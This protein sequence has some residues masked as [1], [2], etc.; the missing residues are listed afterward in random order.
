MPWVARPHLATLQDTGIRMLLGKSIFILPI[1]L[2]GTLAWIGMG[3]LLLSGLNGMRTHDQEANHGLKFV[4]TWTFVPFISIYLFSLFK[5]V[6]QFKQFL[7]LL[8]PLL[9]AVCISLSKIKGRISVVLYM[10]LFLGVTP[11]LILQQTNL[12]KDDWRK[13]TALIRSAYQDGDLIYGNPSAVRLPMS[14]Y[15]EDPVLYK[16]YPPGYTIQKGGWEG[17]QITA[18]IAAEVAAEAVAGHDRIWFVEYNPQFWDP[19]E[20]LQDE[21]RNYAEE[22]IDEKVQGIRVRL[23][24]KS[25]ED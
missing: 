7:I 3:F 19:A 18:D 17:T 13:A 1:W 6:F 14:I 8:A 5:P 12:E 9:M 22:L 21:F 2:R 16:G 25:G 11:A 24:Q 23:Y 4:L 20:L 10:L 15:W